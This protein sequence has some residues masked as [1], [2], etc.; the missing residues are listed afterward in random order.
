M[1]PPERPGLGVELD[2]DAVARY[3]EAFRQRGD[4][5]YFDAA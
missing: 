4:L 5:T 2:Q 3:A 1:V